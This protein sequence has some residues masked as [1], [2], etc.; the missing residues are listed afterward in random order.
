MKKSPRINGL[1]EIAGKRLLALLEQADVQY[2]P[3]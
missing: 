2:D 3:K 1:R